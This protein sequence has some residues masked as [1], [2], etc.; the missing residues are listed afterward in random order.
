MSH[1]RLEAAIRLVYFLPSSPSFSQP[2]PTLFDLPVPNSISS[3][4]TKL[5][6]NIMA[7]VQKRLTI[8]LDADTSPTKRQKTSPSPDFADDGEVTVVNI[9]DSD[10]LPS[11]Y[12]VMSSA[13]IDLTDDSNDEAEDRVKP[14]FPESSP[15]GTESE[16]ALTGP[17]SDAATSGSEESHITANDSDS[18]NEYDIVA[19]KS[20]K[21]A[22]SKEIDRIVAVMTTDP[23]SVFLS[24]IEIE[25]E[26]PFP[27]LAEW[28][29]VAVNK[30]FDGTLRNVAFFLDQRGVMSYI[31]EK[32]DEEQELLGHIT[33]GQ[34]STAAEERAALLD[35]ASFTGDH[36]ET[37][38]K[39]VVEDR[40]EQYTIIIKKRELED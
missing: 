16:E 7:A 5:V 31:M 20:K 9:S 30:T 21:A 11:K 40:G 12:S 29:I 3:T 28:G 23:A 17:A 26:E 32:Y 1:A 18:D 13:C 39:I 2:H 8:D 22:Q 37:S 36:R 4:I 27:A 25:A 6:L 38:C 34:F 10:D 24:E 33:Q 14:Y 19:L 15:T 35:K